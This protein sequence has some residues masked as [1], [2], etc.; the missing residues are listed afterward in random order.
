M[1]VF[2]V[3]VLCD[4][5]FVGECCWSI[6]Y[7]WWNLFFFVVEL[8]VGFDLVGMIVLESI[9]R[10]VLMIVERDYGEGEWWMRLLF[11]ELFDDVFE[12]WC[13]GEVCFWFNIIVLL[14]FWVVKNEW[15]VFSMFLY[16]GFEWWSEY[17][18]YLLFLLLLVV[19]MCMNVLGLWVVIVI[20]KLFGKRYC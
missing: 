18:L 9:D 8:E 2:D 7:I 15:Y 11:M 13:V 12:F 19:L 4:N 1:V 10:M 6:L 17:K 3:I 20:V 14:C 5:F 16:N